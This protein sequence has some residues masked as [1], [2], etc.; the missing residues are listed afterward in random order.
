MNKTIHPIRFVAAVIAIAFVVML[1]LFV[2]QSAHAQ[3]AP[4]DSTAAIAPAPAPADSSAGVIA[5]FIT[6][7][8]GSHPWIVTLATIIGA[9]RLVFKPIVSGV[10]AYVKSTP[11]STDD[12]LVEKVEHSAAFKSFAWCLDFFGSIKIGP[13]FTAKPKGESPS[14]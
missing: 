2:V 9:L 12:E 8:A 1:A 13:Q 6:G 4:A 14:A 7:L 3:A 5:S 11:S 10:E